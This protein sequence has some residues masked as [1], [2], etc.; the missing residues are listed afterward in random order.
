M[1]M[2]CKINGAPIGVSASLRTSSTNMAVAGLPGS[3]VMHRSL[4]LTTGKAV[5]KG[6]NAFEVLLVE[7]FR[8]SIV[9]ATSG[10]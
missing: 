8:D 10:L 4:T 2:K 5:D 9:A 3:S 7:L 1:S 6:A